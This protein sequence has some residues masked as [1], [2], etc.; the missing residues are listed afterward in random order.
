M[1]LLLHGLESPRIDNSL[2]VR[3]GEIGERDRVDVILTNPPFGG[4]EEPRAATAIPR[5][6]AHRRNGAP[7]PTTHHAETASGIRIPRSRGHGRAER[8]TVRGRR[9]ARIKEELLKEFNLHTIVRLPVGV[10]APYTAIPTNLLFFEAR[11]A[12][13]DIWYYEQP[14]PEGRKSYTKTQPLQFEDFPSLHW[15]NEREENERA[16]KVVSR[17]TSRR[18]MQPRSQ[19]PACGKKDIEHL[20][21][22]ELVESILAKEQ[23]ITSILGE[24]K[25]LLAGGG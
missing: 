5:R 11:L 22:A 17:R 18:G 20:P 25:A 4:E 15:W 12:N 9:G 7:L 23:Q 19:E 16:W 14:L 6:Q 10:F 1:N 2:K 8:D 21:P 3:L 13:G 24:I